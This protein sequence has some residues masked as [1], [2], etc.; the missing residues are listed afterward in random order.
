MQGVTDIAETEIITENKNDVLEL[1]DLVDSNIESENTKLNVSDTAQVVESTSATLD[2]NESLDLVMDEDAS[3]YV[4]TKITPQETFQDTNQLDVEKIR[5]SCIRAGT[6]LTKTRWWKKQHLTFNDD[7]HMEEKIEGNI[8][9]NLTKQRILQGEENTSDVFSEVFDEAAFMSETTENPPIENN[10]EDVSAPVSSPELPKVAEVPTVRATPDEDMDLV[11]SLLADLMEEP[12]EE[13]ADG[14][15]FAIENDLPATE[16]LINDGAVESKTEIEVKDTEP[17]ID[18]VTGKTINV[19]KADTEEDMSVLDEILQQSIEDELTL[20]ENL[21]VEPKPTTPEFKPA[22]SSAQTKQDSEI[23]DV[24]EIEQNYTPQEK[25]SVAPTSSEGDIVVLPKTDLAQK[26]SLLSETASVAGL[27][28]AAALLGKKRKKEDKLQD[29][30]QIDEN[31]PVNNIED[32]VSVQENTNPKKDETMAQHAKSETILDE[33][34]V[35]ETSSAFASL[36]SAVSEKTKRDDAGPAIGDL[37]QDALR[38]ML[39]DWLDKNLKGI[40]ERAV[41]KE[42]KRISSGK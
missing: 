22:L 1:I 36:T 15:T 26:L 16:N 30:K 35:T 19:D 11:K 34:T 14:N 9:E 24:Q 20:H 37:V 25:P 13:V 41:T 10:V 39:K 7:P 40:V 29:A 28:T 31:K 12:A 32:V 4:T 21:P 38:P 2:F 8:D 5:R 6:E 42:V 18:F 3:S 27:G 23:A 33:G 17:E